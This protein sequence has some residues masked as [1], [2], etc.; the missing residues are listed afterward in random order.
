MVVV[1]SL[2]NEVGLARR[3]LIDG[4]HFQLRGRWRGKDG[5]LMLVGGVRDSSGSLRAG[6]ATPGE[7]PCGWLDP[8][9]VG[10]DVRRGDVL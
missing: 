4:D 5:W 6:L 10:T 3:V 2:V 1:G 8:L 7:A 9:V